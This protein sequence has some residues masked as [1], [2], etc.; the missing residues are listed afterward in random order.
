MLKDGSMRVGQA[1][2]SLKHCR[3]SALRHDGLLDLIASSCARNGSAPA[4]D[5]VMPGADTLGAAQHSSR[6]TCQCHAHARLLWAKLHAWACCG[7]SPADQAVGEHISIM[8]CAPC[9]T[10]RMPLLLPVHTE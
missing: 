8:A 4:S 10:A 2:T 9:C 5:S 6:L 7:V 1:R 3:K